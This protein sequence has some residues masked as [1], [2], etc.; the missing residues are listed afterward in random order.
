M[1]ELVSSIE[2]EIEPFDCLMNLNRSVY[3]YAQKQNLGAILDGVDGDILLSSSGLL[4]QL[5]HEGKLQ[6][7][8]DETIKA[9][10]LTAEYKTGR[11]EFIE[12]P[13]GCGCFFFSRLAEVYLSTFPVP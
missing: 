5:W 10:G 3:L 12:Q 1:D 9:E 6:A 2:T 13:A 8:L 7:V 4:L 11:E